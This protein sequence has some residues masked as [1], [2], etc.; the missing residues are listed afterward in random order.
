MGASA[1]GGKLCEGG[2][3][4]SREKQGGDIGGIL[5]LCGW[6]RVFDHNI[7]KN[8]VCDSRAHASLDS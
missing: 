2:L 7:K 3:V 6:L 4:D 1:S 5:V 8:Q